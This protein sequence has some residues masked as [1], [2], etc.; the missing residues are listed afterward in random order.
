MGAGGAVAGLVAG[1]VLLGPDGA[2]AAPRPG[3]TGPLP[4][5]MFTLGVASGDPAPDG[6]VLW[7]RLA[8][9]PTGGGGMPDRPVPVRWEVADDERFA[10]LTVSDR[11]KGKDGNA[12]FAR[13][14]SRGQREFNPVI[15]D[16]G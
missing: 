11:G 6:F 13:D 16:I 1:P 14:L 10:L 2:Q 3:A 5:D 4:A 8:P 7:T 12:L 9:D 15:R